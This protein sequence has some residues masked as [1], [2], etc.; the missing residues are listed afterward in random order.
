MACQHRFVAA[1]LFI[2]FLSQV[3]KLD[4]MQIEVLNLSRNKIQKIE[5]CAFCL[6]TKLTHIDISQNGLLE[7]GD[8][9]GGQSYDNLKYF[10]A[11]HNMVQVPVK[12]F[13][14]VPKCFHKKFCFQDISKTIKKFPG[15]EEVHLSKMNIISIPSDMFTDNIFL[16]TINLS[17]NYLVNIDNS[18]IDSLSHLHFLDLS[19]NLFMGLEETFFKSG[20][21]TGYTCQMK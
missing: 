4:M 8:I 13:P 5:N 16:K 10:S 15:L 17:S 2:A 6:C 21:K 9:F 3:D 14:S 19:S 12:T 18:I 11:S 20:N 1:L 7:I